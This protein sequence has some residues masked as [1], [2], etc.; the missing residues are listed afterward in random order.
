MFCNALIDTCS[1]DR[2]HLNILSVATEMRWTRLAVVNPQVIAVF[3]VFGLDLSSDEAVKVLALKLW[4]I[5][6]TV[7]LS[8]ESLCLYVG[9]QMLGRGLDYI[10]HVVNFS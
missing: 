1:G 2:H 10:L 4:S 7:R 6:V 8:L 5:R 9:L 3:G